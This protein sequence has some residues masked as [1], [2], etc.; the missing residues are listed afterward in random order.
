MARGLWT[1]E[2]N[3]MLIRSWVSPLLLYNLPQFW[4]GRN[5]YHDPFKFIPVVFRIGLCAYH[6]SSSS[7][8][9]SF[10]PLFVPTMLKRNNYTQ[11]YLKC[12]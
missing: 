10:G 9:F 11:L 5:A 3:V 6:S 8:T 12:L 7:K 2:Q 1:P 4:E